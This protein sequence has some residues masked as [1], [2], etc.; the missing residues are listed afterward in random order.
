MQAQLDSY[1][2]W[3]AWSALIDVVF[4]HEPASGANCFVEVLCVR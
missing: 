1:R 3:K 4:L 2:Y